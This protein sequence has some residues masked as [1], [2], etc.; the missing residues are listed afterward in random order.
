M[1]ESKASAEAILALTK[2]TRRL[3]PVILARRA[4][5]LK[6]RKVIKY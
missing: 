1:V 3:S 5:R 4:K 6:S 2:I